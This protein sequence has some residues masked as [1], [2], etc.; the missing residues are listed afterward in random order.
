MYTWRKRKNED[1][2]PYEGNGP[3]I[4]VDEHGHLIAQFY[5]KDA[6]DNAQAIALKEAV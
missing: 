4:V 1:W 3:V 2:A 6:E 5:G